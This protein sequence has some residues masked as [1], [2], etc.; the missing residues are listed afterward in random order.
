MED[1]YVTCITL[2]SVGGHSVVSVLREHYRLETSMTDRTASHD[3]Y[4]AF[5]VPDVILVAMDLEND[6]SYLLAHAVAQAGAS[7]A[8]LMLAHA[9]PPAETIAH[10]TSAIAAADVEE[11]E[12]HAKRRL[13]VAAAKVRAREIRCDSVVR[14]GSPAAIIP[15][16]VETSGVTRLILGTHGR[17]LWKR[18]VLGSVADQILRE[19]HI[20]TC[21]IGPHVP[22]TSAD[23]AP[24]KI[25]HPVSL[26]I[27]YEQSARIALEIAQFY[28]AE[29]TL[30]HV[31]DRNIHR[32]YDPTQAVDWTRSQLVKLIPEEAPLW[33]FSS[34]QVEVGTV[35]EQILH[36]AEELGADLIVLGVG[37]EVGFWPISNDNTAYEIIARAKCPVLT[38]RRLIPELGSKSKRELTAPLELR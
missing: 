14:H 26:S 18:L 17:R 4:R 10:D 9:V 35:I 15:E 34:I 1:P 23:E 11:L 12:R 32:E 3:L 19:V 5:A 25:L 31:L 36:A 37:K 7:G 8:N 24:R 22:S 38:L 21:T 20:P 27:G 2:C 6:L 16:L 30:L 33:S 13:E 29:I 28:K